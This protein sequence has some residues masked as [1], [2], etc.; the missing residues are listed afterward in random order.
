VSSWSSSNKSVA[1]V[2]NTG[3]VRTLKKGSSKITAT[4]ISGGKKIKYRFKVTV[5]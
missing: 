3:L 4:F 5:K 1:V 2:S